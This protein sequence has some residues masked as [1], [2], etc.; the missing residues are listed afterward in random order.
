MDE[1][2][3]PFQKILFRQDPD[4]QVKEFHL[5]TVTFG[6]S[7]AIFLAI[8]TLFQLAE[9]CKEEFAYAK[10]IIEKET[11]IDDILSG[12]HVLEEA[13]LAQ[14]HVLTALSSG[15]SLRKITSIHPFLRQGVPPR[16]LLTKI[17]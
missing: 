11:Y 1:A 3:R 7:C 5:K 2:D 4:A 8:R 15:V 10:Q 14:K 17:F 13:K 16:I 12:G 6:V 9:D